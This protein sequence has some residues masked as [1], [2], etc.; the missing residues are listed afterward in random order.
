MESD[1]DGE[2]TKNDESPTDETV[3]AAAVEAAEGVIF[4][5]Y[6]TSEIRDLDVTVRFEEGVL[7]VDVYLNVPDADDAEQVAD[8]AALAARRAVDEL[9]E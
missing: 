4:S 9:L 8:D 7:D 1:T 6:G 3:V 2:S 5:R